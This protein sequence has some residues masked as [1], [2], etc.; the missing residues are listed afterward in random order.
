MI[1]S[2]VN[3]AIRAKG[4]FE[5]ILYR[6]FLIEPLYYIFEK[7]NTFNFIMIYHV[8]IDICHDKQKVGLKVILKLNDG[9][10]NKYRPIS[11]IFL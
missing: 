10:Q 5:L 11:I 2:E 9:G 6:S 8:L 7:I 1:F 4:K 3:S